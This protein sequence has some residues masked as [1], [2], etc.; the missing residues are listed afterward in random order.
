MISVKLPF[1][2]NANEGD[3]TMGYSHDDPSLK[4]GAGGLTIWALQDMARANRFEELD[5]MFHNGLNMD[6]LPVGYS[7]GAGL[8]WPDI[9]SK[10][11]SQM[12]NLLTIE[13]KYLKVDS[14]QLV[15]DATDYFIR[16]CWRGKIFFPSNNKRVSKGKNR[17]KESLLVPS[18]P[19]VP[20]AKFDTMLLDSHPLA[21]GATSNVVVLSYTDP[22]TRPYWAELVAT[23]IQGYDIQ[24]AVKGKYG[25]LYIGKTWFGKYDQQGEFIA[26]DPDKSVAFYFLDFNEGALKEQREKHL[27]GAK[28][29]TLDPLPH[30]DN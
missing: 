20:Q 24:V 19:I 11:I 5:N 3:L 26:S 15:S 25:P 6:A 27:D 2:C 1:E 29:E 10:I 16:K 22:Q 4:T 18:S 13:G 14:R 21:K 28:E 30:V 17:I 23:T 12:L 9:G 7:A 8:P